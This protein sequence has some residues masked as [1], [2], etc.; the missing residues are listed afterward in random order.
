MEHA[1]QT[2]FT[3]L[4]LIAVTLLLS[5]SCDK[6][7]VEAID[8]PV[9]EKRATVAPVRS[10]TATSLGEMTFP[11]N[12]PQTDAKVK[13]GHQLFFDA[14]LSSDGSR[15]CYS[16]HTNE[17][18]NGGKDPIAIGPGEKKLTRHSP[19]IWNVGF[20]GAYYWDGRSDSLESQATAAWA[21]G[22]MGVG[23]DNLVAK[24]KEIEAIAGY[25]TQFD[26]AFPGEGVTPETIVKALSA[27]ERTLICDDTAYDRHMK[28]DATALTD[29][30]KR[31]LEL[32][33]GAAGCVACHTPPFFSSS[34]MAK[35]G[36]YFNVGIGTAGKKDDEVDIGRMA[37]TKAET[38]WA[39]F[40]VPS[41]RNISKSA[42]Y[43][44]DGS[45]A[46]LEAAVRLMASGGIANKNLSPI[47]TDKKLGDDQVKDLVAFLGALDCKKALE[48]PTL[49]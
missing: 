25:K 44:H 30:E 48:Q 6:K 36:T 22:N 7:P 33:N 26:V 23:K 3:R 40:K 15:S 29:V 2:L 34:Y 8:K 32:F 9:D 13:L 24:A 39:A 17:D 37:V 27:Y 16:C 5:S 18:G 21:G 19:V 43:F 35:T 46:T 38:D 14:R 47:L 4:S 20:L 45:V 31:G 1:M 28:G 10:A 41:L 12:N 49:P 42:P 11:Q